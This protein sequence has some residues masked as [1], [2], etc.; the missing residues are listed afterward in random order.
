MEKR[1]TAIMLRAS[2]LRES[3]KSVR[4]FSVEEGLISAVMRGVKKPN[5]KLKFA[6]QPFAFCSY[7]LT[8][9]AGKY[10]VTGAT[11]IEDMYA[12][13]LD[14]LKYAA[15]CVMSEATEKAAQSIEPEKLFLVLLKALK[16][17]IYGELASELIVIKFIQKLLSMSGFMQIPKM[18][19]V[20]PDSPAKLLSD[21][22]YRSLDELNGVNYDGKIAVR[23]LKNIAAA[24]ENTYECKL[25]SLPVYW[26][27]IA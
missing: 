27:F 14:T 9:K 3:D 22:A 24:F 8:E 20:T 19:D 1:L 5:A 11:A 25:K 18:R 7:E 2:D 16:T 4:L 13:C 21:I 26:G 6:S 17:L 23:A 12:V 15:A 10:T